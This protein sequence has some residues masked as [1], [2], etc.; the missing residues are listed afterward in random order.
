MT[1][2]RYFLVLI[3]TSVNHVDLVVDQKSYKWVLN[4][5]N[6]FKDVIVDRMCESRKEHRGKKVTFVFD[7]FYYNVKDNEYHN[8]KDLNDIEDEVFAKVPKKPTN[9]YDYPDA[10]APFHS[11]HS[12]AAFKQIKHQPR[13]PL[14][15]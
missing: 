3:E 9:L 10:S 11:S 4:S 15:P 6:E 5:I 1:T 14:T 12:P 13:R 7:S 2:E 8:F